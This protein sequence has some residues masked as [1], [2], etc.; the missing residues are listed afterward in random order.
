MLLEG[1]VKYLPR[2]Q[3]HVTICALGGRVSRSLEAGADRVV[4]L[5]LT[6]DGARLALEELR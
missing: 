5:P 3:F 6:L 4:R 2:P 1:V